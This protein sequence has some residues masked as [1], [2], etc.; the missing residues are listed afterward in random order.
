MDRDILIVGARAAGASLGLLLAQRG[1]RVLLVDRDRFPSDT[2]STHYI[3]P[4]QVPLLARLGVLDE[5]LAAGFRRMT[6]ARAYVDDCLFE[7]PIAPAPAFALAP[8]RDVLDMLL[9]E[10]AVRYGA[11]F[12]DRTRV[13]RL[14]WDGDRV[15]GA[16]LASRS[17]GARRVDARV[18]VGADGKASSVAKW[19]GAE[20]Y[21][22]VPA[23][24]PAY[25][26]HY[27]GVA[28]LDEPAL[29]IFFGG[30]RLGFI[31]P[32]RPGEDCLAMEMQPGDFAAARS[33]PQEYFE[34]RFR[35]LPGMAR[36]LS[37]A[38]L[39]GKLIGTKGIENYFR[40]PYGPGWV[41]AGDA[42]YLKDPSTGLGIGDALQQAL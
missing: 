23:M 7:A 1:Y 29:E 19:V 4:F 25:Y 8:R 27:Q 36:R 34:E 6:R 17:G 42:A 41:L 39:D 12:L 9:V 2:M 22:A 24:R 13:E 26:G 11:E 31:F 38:R 40:K 10:H 15:V 37:G 16:E 35:K 32:M 3:H 20:T 28:P 30:D 18:V 14:L 33:R 21:N 5:L